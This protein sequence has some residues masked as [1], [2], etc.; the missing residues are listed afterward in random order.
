MIGRLQTLGRRNLQPGLFPQASK[1]CVVQTG[2]MGLACLGQSLHSRDTCVLELVHLLLSNRRHPTQMIR[3]LQQGFSL[4]LPAA[5]IAP[6]IR[7]WWMLMMSLMR[8]MRL[9]YK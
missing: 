7:Q 8:L 5:I 9:L 4:G 2:N 1:D 3:R 6:Q